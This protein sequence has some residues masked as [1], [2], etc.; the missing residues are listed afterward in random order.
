MLGFV[1]AILSATA[2]LYAAA[3]LQYDNMYW[4]TQTCTTLQWACDAPNA[5]AAAGIIAAVSLLILRTLREST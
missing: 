1:A 2:F 3:S 5:V 4:A